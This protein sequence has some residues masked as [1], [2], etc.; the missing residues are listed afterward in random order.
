MMTEISTTH[1]RRWLWPV[2][3]VVLIIILLLGYVSYLYSISPLVVRQPL[4][5]HYH[6][7][8]Q[9]IA[10]GKAVHFNTAA[11]QEGLSA[12]QCNLQLSSEPVHFHDNKDQM[13]H[14]HWE[15]MTGGLVLKDYGWNY[16]GGP[17]NTLGYRFDDLKHGL[18]RVSIHGKSLPN[19]AAGDHFYVYTGDE[20]G[21]KQRSFDDFK[22]QDLEKFFGK[23][24]NLPLH[25]ENKKKRA[26][27]ADLFFPAA[28]AHSDESTAS[29]NETQ[30][31]KLIRINN[32]IGNVVIF[33]QKQP[34]T[35]A[36]IKDRL[37]HL[38]PL[39]DSTCGG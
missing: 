19:L 15:G 8:L 5:E 7:R 10:D 32:L 36:Q 2:C 25:Q 28:Y 27:L 22:N 29:A 14:I 17:D 30:T 26:G 9:I 6:F 35:V 23:T 24:S 37:N 34:P 12:N 39:S 38:E 11:F 4:P 13:V 20:N 31:E 3:A 18:K 21:Y 1:K 16:V 33:A